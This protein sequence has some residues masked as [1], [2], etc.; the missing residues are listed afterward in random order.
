MKITTA[1]DYSLRALAYLAK[2]TGK[3]IPLSA[4]ADKEKLPLTFLEQLFVELKK[5]CLVTSQRGAKGGYTLAKTADQITVQDVLE[6]VSGQL[7]IIECNHDY[8]PTPEHCSTRGVW[9][10]LTQH[11]NDLLSKITLADLVRESK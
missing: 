1:E 11:I 10:K 2:H 8:C 3:P 7:E 5:A 9:L 4:I 6:A